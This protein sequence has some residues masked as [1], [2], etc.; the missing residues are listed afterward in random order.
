MNIEEKPKNF[1]ESFGTYWYI[2]DQID[3]TILSLVGNFSS[4]LPNAVITSRSFQRQNDLESDLVVKFSISDEDREICLIKKMLEIRKL[5]ESNFNESS[6]SI[7]LQARNEN[8][9]RSELK[10]FNVQRPTSMTPQFIH[11]LDNLSTI[12]FSLMEHCRTVREFVIT[13]VTT[14]CITYIF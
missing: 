11:F 7:T 10:A 1:T 6:T 3:D 13:E 8:M 5:I 9:S 12:M 4:Q 2:Y 14:I